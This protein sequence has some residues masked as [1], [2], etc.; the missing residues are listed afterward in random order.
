MKPQFGLKRPDQLKAAADQGERVPPG[1]F[2]S[3][4]FPV[5]TY[6]ST[7][8]V[9]LDLP[10]RSLCDAQ[11]SGGLLIAV[12]AEKQDA[13]LTELESTGVAGALVVGQITEGPVG[14]IQ[15]IP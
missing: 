12:A 8:K 3:Q 2:L 1:Q 4:K 5:L 11:T 7:P 13:L 10:H 14:Q 15:V 6:G 9:D